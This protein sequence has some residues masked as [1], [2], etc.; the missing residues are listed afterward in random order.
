MRRGQLG[1][2][3]SCPQA[4]GGEVGLAGAAARLR[5]VTRLLRGGADRPPTLTRGGQRLRAAATRE[6]SWRLFPTGAAAGPAV[7]G[8]RRL[9]PLFNPFSTS[10]MVP[11]DPREGWV[12]KDSE[13]AARTRAAEEDSTGHW[14]GGGGSGRGAG[15]SASGAGCGVVGGSEGGEGMV[16]LSLS[17]LHFLA[18]ESANFPALTP[19][20]RAV[21]GKGTQEFQPNHP[22]PR[23]HANPR[24]PSAAWDSLTGACESGCSCSPQFF[25][26]SNPSLRPRVGAL[27][28]CSLPF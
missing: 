20:P 4:R 1:S 8:P 26:S 19:A 18:L 21:A 28:G 15:P 6:V 27:R 24:N 9:F 22:G 10:E 17:P 11:R 23:K 3:A 7:R 16:H 5:A 12:W 2:K 13:L 25:L 14:L